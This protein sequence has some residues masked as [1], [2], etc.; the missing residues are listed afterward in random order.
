MMIKAFVC[1]LV[2]AFVVSANAAATCPPTVACSNGNETMVC[3]VAGSPAHTTLAGLVTGLTGN[4]CT[5]I[6]AAL[7]SSGKTLFAP[8]NAA[9]AATDLQGQDVPTLLTYHAL[10]A[11]VLSSGIPFDTA[12]DTLAANKTLRLTQNTAP[13]ANTGI[14]INCQ[15]NVSIPDLLTDNDSVVHSIS[16]KLLIP[17]PTVAALLTANNGAGDNDF[18]ILLNLTIKYDLV[19]TLMMAAKET[20]FAPTNKAFRAAFD[21]LLGAGWENN[22]DNFPTSLDTWTKNTITYHVTAATYCGQAFDVA[23][24][25]VT[26]N[27]LYSGFDV[28]VQTSAA[29]AISVVDALGGRANVVAPNLVITQGVVHGVDAVLL[30][31]APP[32]DATTT[33][34]SASSLVPT[35]FALVLLCFMLA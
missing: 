15:A 26:V 4:D 8:D 9:I 19:D 25:N 28:F 17:T 5:V 6:M 31:S 23:N 11:K 32:T 12:V 16:R 1:L 22:L 14:L 21:P 3:I 18:G 7:E 10:G 24:L 13:L 35:L 20:I 27:T 2:A 33:P 30:P 29:K 34:S